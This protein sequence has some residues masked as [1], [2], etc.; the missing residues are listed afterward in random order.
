MYA[1]GQMAIQPANFSFPNTYGAWKLGFSRFFTPRPGF[2]PPCG[3]FRADLALAGRETPTPERRHPDQVVGAKGEVWALTLAKPMKRA[4][5]K[6][7]TVLP[8][9]KTSS[10]R[11]RMPKLRA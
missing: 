10:I 2:L 4:L 8:Q 7:P 11:L 3:G 6:S 1:F 5:R 9:P